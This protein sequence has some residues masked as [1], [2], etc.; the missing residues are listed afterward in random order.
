MDNNVKKSYELAR[1]AYAE[2]GVDTDK[3]LENLKKIRLHER[4]TNIGDYAF[5]DCINFATIYI[6]N[7]VN[8][9]GDNAFENVNDK[10]I[11]MCSFGSYAETYAQNKK[12]KYQLV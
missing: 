3:V 9:I 2:I 7:S 11:L 10:F 12:I 8:S 6:P 5:A 4:I 1:A